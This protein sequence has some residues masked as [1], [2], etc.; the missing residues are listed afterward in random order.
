MIL[1]HSNLLVVT[2]IIVSGAQRFPE[3]DCREKVKGQILCISAAQEK[4]FGQIHLKMYKYIVLKF[5]FIG[6]LDAITWRPMSSCESSPNR[7]Q[8][9]VTKM[10]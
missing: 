2:E 7:Q 9:E 3:T 8:K 1:L 10:K 5:K 4:V 6:I